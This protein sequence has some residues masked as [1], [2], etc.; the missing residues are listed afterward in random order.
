MTKNVTRKMIF[1]V[2][3]I[4]LVLLTINRTTSAAAASDQAMQALYQAAKAEGEVIWQF[5]GPVFLVKPV[6]AAFQAQYP[7]IKLRVFS[8]G[9]ASIGTRIIT[10]AGA[11]KV[12]LDVGTSFPYY[13]LPLMK[14]NL[15]VTEDWIK[16]GVPEDGILLDGASVTLYHSPNIWVYNK[17]KISEAEAPKTWE[18]VLDPKWKGGKIS[19]RAAATPFAPLFPAWKKDGQKVAKY[20]EQLGKQEVIPGKRNSAVASRVASG[21]C[22]IGTVP[23]EMLLGLLKKG[24]PL[25]VCPVS[26]TAASP[27]S[28]AVPKGAPHPNAAKFLIA[29]LYSP[30]GRKA[31]QKGGR[32]PLTPCNASPSAQL[33]CD[34]SITYTPITSMED[35]RQYDGPFSKMVVDTMA[36]LPK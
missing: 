8:Y 2:I 6:A 32:G 31:L 10:E 21:E 33:L 25:A 14:R 22:P 29:W 23:L 13:F 34:N 20:L 27:V 30:E 36:F 11:G 5:M 15:L 18:D 4:T 7:D 16:I 26:P 19:I 28:L 24:A 3:G 35:L 9:A 17:N 12:S 1:F